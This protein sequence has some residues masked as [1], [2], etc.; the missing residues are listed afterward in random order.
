MVSPEHQKDISTT[1]ATGKVFTPDEWEAYVAQEVT[2]YRVEQRKLAN[3]E[4]AVGPIILEALPELQ[5]II[6]DAGERLAL[7]TRANFGSDTYHAEH[8]ATHVIAAL[9]CMWTRSDY[10]TPNEEING[11]DIHPLMHYSQ[12]DEKHV[13]FW[14]G[15]DCDDGDESE[16]AS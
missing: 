10:F 11:M 5:R 15:L 12:F 3:F 2:V 1:E 14:F 8:F 7:Q 9:C 13:R 16:A 4:A 6:L